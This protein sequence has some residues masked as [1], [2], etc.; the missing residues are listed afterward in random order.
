MTKTKNLLSIIIVSYNTQHLTL[1][2]LESVISQINKSKLL[3]G[4]TEIIV[5][6]NNS[7]D[8]SVKEI[9]KLF[10]NHKSKIINQVISNKDNKGFSS[11]NNQGIEKSS[12]K[13]VLFLNSDTIVQNNALDIMVKTF[14]KTPTDESTSELSSEG[15][16]IDRLGILAAQLLNPDDTVQHQGGDFPT[17]ISLANHMFFLDDLPIIGKLFKSTQH[18]GRNVKAQISNVKPTAKSWVGGAA[19]MV[20]KE[21]FDEIGMLDSNIFMYGEDV[22]FCMRAK[23]HHWDIA[24]QPNAHITHFGSASSSSENAILGEIKGYIYIWAKHKPLWQMWF[25]KFLLFWGAL[26]RIIIFG[27]ILRDRKRAGVYR[28]ALGI[29]LN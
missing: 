5:V 17:L 25:L 10:I 13:Y 4:K 27:T 15:N 7:S 23:K 12:G 18:T 16:K 14:E 22:E 24:I 6:D 26:L 11:A 28:K 21:V 3:R 1:Q 20:K 8:D 29:I 19:M 9:K 2:T